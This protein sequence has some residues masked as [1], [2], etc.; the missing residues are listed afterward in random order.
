MG[1]QTRMGRWFGIRQRIRV[2]TF[3]GVRYSGKAEAVGGG[4]V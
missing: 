1:L 3:E 2:G 4:V